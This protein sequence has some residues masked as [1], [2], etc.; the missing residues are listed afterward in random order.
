MIT[1]LESGHLLIGSMVL[2]L[3]GKFLFSAVSFGSGA[4]GGIFFP[5]L[6][7]GALIGAVFAMAGV[8]FFGLAP[9]YVNHFVLLGMTGFFTAIVRAPLTGII[10]LFEM[11]GSI[12][13]MLSLSIVSVTAYIV[14]TLMRSEP[15]YDSLLKR[16]LK[17]DTIVHDK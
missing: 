3:L 12:S 15:I 17:A 16:I 2:L 11:S 10:L 6:I 9:V 1:R 7:L 14:A 4:P 13:Q 5:L 8:E